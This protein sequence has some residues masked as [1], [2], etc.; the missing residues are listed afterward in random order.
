MGEKGIEIPLEVIDLEGD[1]YHLLL[2]VIVAEK[3]F[4]LVLDTGASKTVFDQQMVENLIGA[5]HILASE[6]TSTGLGATGIP[7]FTAVIDR[8]GFDGLVLENQEVAILNLST[9]NEAYQELINEPILGVLGSDI[10]M[11]KQAVIDF[12][13]QSVLL[14]TDPD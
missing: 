13:K 5:E 4:K 11:A 8:I 3:P 1:G 6:R 12:A 14:H 7:S 9:I 10:L 2:N